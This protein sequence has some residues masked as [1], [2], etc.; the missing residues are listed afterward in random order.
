MR[1]TA[2]KKA[3]ATALQAPGVEALNQRDARLS[4][5]RKRLVEEPDELASTFNL[6]IR[7]IGIDTG[8]AML[9]GPI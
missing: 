2:I 8:A 4:S 7:L 6:E 9:F 3:N 1:A 5:G